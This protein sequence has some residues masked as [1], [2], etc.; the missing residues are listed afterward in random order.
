MNNHYKP[1][2]I[3]YILD[4]QLFKLALKNEALWHFKYHI[5][6]IKN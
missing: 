3:I 5:L 1:L 6:W 4:I 2:S